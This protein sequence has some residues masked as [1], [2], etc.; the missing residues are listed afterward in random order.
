MPDGQEFKL[1]D[2]TSGQVLGRFNTEQRM[3]CHV[4]FSPDGKLLAGNGI[5]DRVDVWDV[6]TGQRLSRVT[7]R[8]GLIQ[9]ALAFSPDGKLLAAPAGQVARVWDAV[10]GREVFSL[11]GH[12]GRVRAVAWGPDGHSLATASADLTVRVWDVATGEETRVFRGHAGSVLS[13][14]FRPDGHQ[15]VS[16]DS[17]GVLKA[18][19]ATREQ[20]VLTLLRLDAV[21]DIAFTPDNQQVVAA[22]ASAVRAWDTTAG[23]QVFTQPLK[24]APRIEGLSKYVALSGDGR[25]FAGPARGD[26]TVLRV[27][28]V[29]SGTEVASL[30]GHKT[31]IRCVAFSPEGRML[32]SCSREKSALPLFHASTVGLLGSPLGQGPF[33][34]APPVFLGPAGG[35]ADLPSQLLLWQLPASGEAPPPLSLACPV[36]VQSLAFSADG[37]RLV[38][39]E[40][41]SLAADGQEQTSGWVSVWDTSTG[42]L[43]QRWAGHPGPVQCVA[44]DPSGRRVAS[45]GR[46]PD[47]TVCVWDAA[48]GERLHVLQG[49]AALTGLTF[50]PDGRRLAAVGIDGWVQLW[51]PATGQAILTLRPPGPLRAENVYGE[52]QVV[53]SRDGTRL[54]VNSWRSRIFVWDGRPLTDFPR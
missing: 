40:L 1:L 24:L 35:F 42:R 7:I 27:W 43:L 10:S 51:D 3:A 23:Q 41:G 5:D 36:G 29:R 19:D 30:R 48:T 54:A 28:D 50:S 22:N 21:S 9:N 38:A 6:G 17:E 26:P 44:I 46:M 2:L 18:W 37:Q 33:L 34:A 12:T 52:S 20:Q 53:F 13:V 8:F 25:L 32:A 39:G 11:Q 14:A 49:P 15:I 45:G 16:G 31:R 4:V 47:Q